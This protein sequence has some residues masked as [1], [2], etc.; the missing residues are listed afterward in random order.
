M[1]RNKVCLLFLI[2]SNIVFSQETESDTIYVYEDVIIRDTVYVK[3]AGPEKV[4]EK[5][6]PKPK[7]K[8]IV[9]S[10]IFNARLNSGYFSNSLLKEMNAPDKIAFGLG[11]VA[12]KQILLPDLSVGIGADGFLFMGSNNIE[13]SDSESKLNGYYF[14]ETKEP[15]LFKSIKS[16]NYLVQIPLQFY[17]KIKKFT[18]SA[19][20]V[21][22]YC[23]YKIQMEGASGTLPLTFDEIQDFE[24]HIFQVGWIA[25]LQYLVWRNF[26]VGLSFSSGKSTNLDFKN[27]KSENLIFL[28]SSSFVENKWLLHLSYVF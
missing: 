14:T 27:N 26:A 19:G 20:I 21:V 25:E 6:K 4:K 1:F 18:P 15:K 16:N 23:Q 8:V 28:K 9:D 7:P 10:W 17:Y 11:F 12:R 24:A 2:F 22:S 3:K 13:S 5:V